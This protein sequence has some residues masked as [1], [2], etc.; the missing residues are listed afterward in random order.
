MQIISPSVEILGNP[1]SRQMLRN[2]E[3]AGRVCYKSEANIKENTA[4]PFLRRLVQSGHESVIEHEKLSVK[5][6]CDRGVTHE[7]VRHRIASYSQESTR[8]CNYTKDKFGNELTFIKPLFWD[9]GDTCYTLWKEQMA[10]IEK[11]YF[12]L[13]EAGATPEEARSVL[14]NSLKTEIVVTMNMREWRHFF[15]LRGSK[16]AHPQIREIVRLLLPKFRE[17]LP[18]LFEDIVID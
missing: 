10:S 4:G 18:D 6:I 9:E 13:I 17:L 3:A 16:A 8:Y 15:R 14:P 12:A 7:I 1:D 5:I 2:M 11:G